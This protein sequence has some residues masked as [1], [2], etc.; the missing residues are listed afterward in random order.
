[1]ADK[2][3]LSLGIAFAAAGL[4]LHSRRRRVRRAHPVAGRYRCCDRSVFAMADVG[5]GKYWE[6]IYFIIVASVIAVGAFVGHFLR[7]DITL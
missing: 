1:M 7:V 4:T 5:D 2:S 6:A 3:R